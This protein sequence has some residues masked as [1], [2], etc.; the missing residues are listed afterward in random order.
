VVLRGI[1]VTEG[2]D[3]KLT[4]IV[5]KGKWKLIITETNRLMKYNYQFK[6]PVTWNDVELISF[7]S[8]IETHDLSKTPYSHTPYCIGKFNLLMNGGLINDDQDP[9]VD[10]PPKV[11]L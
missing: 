1:N 9:H 4:T 8:Q 5:M 11:I 6:L 3:E 7:R 10:Y 2:I